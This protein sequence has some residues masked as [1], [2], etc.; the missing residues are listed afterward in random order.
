MTEEE[1]SAEPGYLNPAEARV[2]GSLLEKEMTTPDYYPLSLNGLTNACNQ[3][4]N[5]QPV[6]LMEEAMVREMADSLRER[7]LV[8]MVHEADARVPKFKHSIENLFQLDRGERAVLCELL[9]R[10]PQT[11]SELRTRC[12][13]MHPF[14]DSAEV[15]RTIGGLLNYPGR[16]LA[17]RLSRQSGQK[18]QRYMHLLSGPLEE[19]PAGPSPSPSPGGSTGDHQRISALEAEVAQLRTEVEELKKALEVFRRQF[20]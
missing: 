15:E 5:R 12:A 14:S 13:R 20:E 4:S 6:M 17:G 19:L 16:P 3:K 1:T 7:K 18:E 2:L 10:G 9:L 11:A 8:M